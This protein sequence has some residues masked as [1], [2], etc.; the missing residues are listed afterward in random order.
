[1]KKELNRALVG[2]NV[3]R[4]RKSAGLTQTQLA[5]RVGC[6]SAYISSV[7][8]GAKSMSTAAT[9]SFAEALGVSCDALMREDGK[10]S[11]IQNIVQLIS[12]M[13]REDVVKIEKVIRLLFGTE[14]QTTNERSANDN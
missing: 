13:S 9:L 14:T 5:E 10:N 6:S 8:C 12:K 4:Y 7:E 11:N 3:S 1:M 2:K